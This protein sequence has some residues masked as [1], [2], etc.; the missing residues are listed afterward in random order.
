[1]EFAIKIVVKGFYIT[2]FSKVQD[3]WGATNQGV[4]VV[5]GCYFNRKYTYDLGSKAH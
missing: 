2:N 4:G 3:L 5:G 1:M